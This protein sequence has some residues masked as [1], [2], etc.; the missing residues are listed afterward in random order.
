MVKQVTMYEAKDGSVHTTRDGAIAAED[1]FDLLECMRDNPFYCGH[2]TESIEPERLLEWLNDNSVYVKYLGG[3][4][5]DA[6]NK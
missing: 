4:K 6:E 3:H 5:D 2:C 1:E